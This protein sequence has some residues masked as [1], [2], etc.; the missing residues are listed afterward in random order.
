M[1]ENE[2][3][4]VGGC[5]WRETK[6]RRARDAMHRA[7]VE[8]VAEHGAA[9]VTTEMIAERAGVSPR[10]FFNYWGSKEAAVLGV[11]HD[12]GAQAAGLLRARPADEPPHE[13]VRAVM[14]EM[15]ASVLDDPRLRAAK[16]AAIEREPQIQQLSGRAMVALTGELTD[17][18]AERLEGPDARDRALL[19]VQLAYTASRCAFSLSMT[20][21]TPAREELDRVFALL[22]AG[23]IVV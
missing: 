22:D 19:I 14:R 12:R 6:K 7:A 5:G 3:P 10:T 11:S 8:L 23:E 9:H 15:T 13:S 2:E 20:R 21:G 18:L 17:A 4:A 16:R 1:T